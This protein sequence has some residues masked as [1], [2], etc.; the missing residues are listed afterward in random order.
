[1]VDDLSVS[2]TFGRQIS[3]NTDKDGAGTEYRILVNASGEILIEQYPLDHLVD[4]IL[5]YGNTAADGSGNDWCLLVDANGHLQIDVL[6]M[7]VVSIQDG[8]NVIS[9][10]D[11]GGS[12]T[13]DFT[14]PVPVT[15]NA[16]SLT[17][18]DGAGSLTI[19]GNVG[20]IGAALTALQLIDNI[21]DIETD[22]DSIATGQNLQTQINLNYAWDYEG[23]NDWQRLMSDG[24]GALYVVEDGAALTALQLIDN[25]V[26]TETEDDSIPAGETRQ[27]EVSLLYGFDGS[28]WERIKT[29]GSG[30]LAVVSA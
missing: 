27:T 25:I 6:T 11:A 23:D 10:D 9:V 2:S 29:D 5:V 7:P 18:D 30:N 12:L 16:G 15:D 4:D 19:D 1:M 3:G 8:G 28:A 14:R 20:I 13:V 17:V 24:G 22:D 21:V 26:N